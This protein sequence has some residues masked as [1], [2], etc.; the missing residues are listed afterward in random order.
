M[1]AMP[2]AYSNQIKSLSGQL[3]E[4]VHDA[5][6][7]RRA[8]EVEEAYQQKIA[9]RVAELAE[10]RG[11]IIA[12]RSSGAHEG[13]DAADLALI[14]AD[15]EGLQPLLQEAAVKVAE[16]QRAH[17]AYT[18]RASSLRQQLAELQSLAKRDAL[19]AYLSALGAKMQEGLAGLDE[20][21]Q[22][23]GYTG[24]PLWSPPAPLWTVLRRL[25]AQSG[26]L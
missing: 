14:A 12:R 16:T 25:A 6:V 19:V 13:A 9:S 26:L 15:L 18:A 24:K 7:A 23:T 21:A 11:H 8:V 17:S 22:V 20:A 4:S 5:G 1:L 10:Q 2:D 3:A